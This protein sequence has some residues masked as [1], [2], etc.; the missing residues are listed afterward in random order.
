MLSKLSIVK[1]LI[2]FLSIFLI[3]QVVETNAQAVQSKSF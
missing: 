1:Y 3:Y 2:L